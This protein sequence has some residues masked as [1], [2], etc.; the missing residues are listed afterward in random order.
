M[1]E[2]YKVIDSQ[3]PTFITCTIVGWVDL[4]IRRTYTNILYDS[5]NYCIKEKGLRVH[6][7]VF[8]TS[9][10]HLIVTSSSTPLNQIVRDFKKHTAKEL[11]KAIKET[12]ESRREWLLNKFS[13]AANRTKRGRNYKVWQDGFHPVILDTNLKLKQ[14][15]DYIH[16]NPIGTGLVL[17]EGHWAHSS[18]WS[19]TDEIVSTNLPVIPLW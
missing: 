12:P 8:M 3:T 10:V 17:E 11:I 4:F 1:S 9:H 7:F 13:Y 5:L 6:A 2:R 19:Y 14:R 15:V 16:Y 18:Y